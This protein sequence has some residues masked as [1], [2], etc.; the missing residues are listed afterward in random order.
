MASW[1]VDAFVIVRVK[2]DR[3]LHVER[4]LP[5]TCASDS[6]HSDADATASAGM[7]R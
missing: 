3:A 7:A 6:T 5:S 2:L 1:R 4:Y